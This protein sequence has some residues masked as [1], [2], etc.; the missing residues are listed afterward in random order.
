M[1]GFGLGDL[2]LAPGMGRPQHQP[3]RDCYGAWKKAYR[4]WEFDQTYQGYS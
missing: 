1:L 4:L 2:R 3:T